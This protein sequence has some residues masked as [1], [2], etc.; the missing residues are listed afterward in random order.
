MAV[1]VQKYGGSSVAD[2][3]KVMGVAR[4]V[5]ATARQGNQVVVVVS[6]RAT[7]LMSSLSR[8]KPFLRIRLNGRWTCS[9]P[10]EQ[11]SMHSWPWPSMP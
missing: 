1:I 9:W 6:A 11:V 10:Q 4:R 3:E 8:L 5:V 2:T 7:P